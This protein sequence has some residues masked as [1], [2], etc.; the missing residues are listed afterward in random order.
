MLCGNQPPTIQPFISSMKNIVCSLTFAFTLFG[1]AAKPQPEPTPFFNFNSKEYASRP[2]DADRV[3]VTF[4]NQND[5]P[6]V[7]RNVPNP[8]YPVNPHKPMKV[9]IQREDA[10]LGFSLSVVETEGVRHIPLESKVDSSGNITVIM[11]RTERQALTTAK[12]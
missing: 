7:V 10:K 5:R 11:P 12:N 4:V 2:I 6:L 8:G 3:W 9:L 1:C